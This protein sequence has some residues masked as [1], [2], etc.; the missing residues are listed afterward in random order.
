MVAVSHHARDKSLDIE[1]F[2]REYLYSG[3]RRADLADCPYEQFEH[4]LRQAVDVGLQD[5]T[6]MSV[7]TVDSEGRPWQR[8]VLLKHQDNQGFVFYTNLESRK[9]TE[10]AGNPQVSLHFPWMA[11]DRQVIIGGVVEKLPVFEAAKYF[12]TRPRE[13]QLAAWA[14]HQ[15]RP[16]RARDVLNEK[17]AELKQKFS[18]GEI[19]LPSFWGGYRVRPERIEFWQGGANRLHDRFYYQRQSAPDSGW[20]IERLA[21]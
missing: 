7:A 11:L 8:I 16:L 6:A 18:D 1:H 17:V 5:P 19:P 9:A 21:P 20:T 12:I 13:S 14:S 3:L 2:R 15:S 10:I 4:W